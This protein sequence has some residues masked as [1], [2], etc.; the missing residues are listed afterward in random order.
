MS[1]PLMYPTGKSGNDFTHPF[2]G[3]HA[4]VIRLRASVA[5]VNAGFTLLPARRGIKWQI[6][7]GYMIA[8]GGAASGA[9][10]VRILGTRAGS[11]VA[12]AVAAVAGLTQSTLI[13]MGAAAVVILADGAS[14][15]PLDANTAVT[16]GKTGGTL[17]TSTFVDFM[18]TYSPIKA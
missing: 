3:N 18:V 8:I 16:V 14:F 4:R 17:A 13:R 15:T 5:Q 12:L 10:D 6:D 9:T 1:T 2:A 11:S 7:D